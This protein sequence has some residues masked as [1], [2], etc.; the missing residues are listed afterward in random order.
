MWSIRKQRNDVVWRNER[1]PRAIVFD[2][3]MSFLSGWRNAKDVN[4]KQLQPNQ[5]VESNV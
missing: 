2:K 4:E 5:V 3:G 1:F